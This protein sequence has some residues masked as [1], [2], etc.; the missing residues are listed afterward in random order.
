MAVNHT[1]GFRLE[2]RSVRKSLLA[3][4][5]KPC[6]IYRRM[7]DVNGEACLSQKDIYKW[8][9]DEFARTSL[10]RKDSLFSGNI[11]TLL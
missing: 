7:W 8:A 3:E 10:S 5:C 6:E 9:K 2:K 11:L 4:K 1:D